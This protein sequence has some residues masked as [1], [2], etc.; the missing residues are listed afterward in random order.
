MGFVDLN[1]MPFEVLEGTNRKVLQGENLTM[2]F[3]DREPNVVQD[4][5]HPMEQVVFLREGRLKVTM[6]G[7]DHIVEAGN[8]VQIPGGLQHRIETLTQVKILSVY[9]PARD[10]S[11]LTQ[12]K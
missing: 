2:L 5:S 7:E 10:L 4:H 3:I 1:D 6:G 8:A 11:A 12:P 9:S